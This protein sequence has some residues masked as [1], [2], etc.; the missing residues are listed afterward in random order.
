MTSLTIHD[1]L[2][3]GLWSFGAASCF[4]FIF[5]TNKSDVCWGALFGA[6]GWM[7]Y[8]GIKAKTESGAWANLAGAFAVAVCSEICALVRRR[9]ATVFLVPG[10]LPLVPGGGIYT[11]MHEAVQANLDR[12]ASAGY[13]T[14]T[15]A[16]SIA[17]GIAVASSLA[18]IAVH[19]IK[20]HH[21]RRLQRAERAV[22][23]ADPFIDE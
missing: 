22:P 17:L 3:A 11:M 12:A 20:K 9:P 13:L 8:V 21:Q 23:F 18:R 15:A 4:A 2:F 10:I 14:L 1:I 16:G 5:N 7:L 6:L 19:V